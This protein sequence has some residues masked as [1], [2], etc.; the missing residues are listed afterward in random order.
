MLHNAWQ[1]IAQHSAQT[2]LCGIQRGI[3]GSLSYHGCWWCPHFMM[4]APWAFIWGRVLPAL[5]I[6]PA[7]VQLYNSNHFCQAWAMYIHT[8]TKQSKISCCSLKGSQPQRQI[9]GSQELLC[10]PT[11]ALCLMLQLQSTDVHSPPSL[12]GLLL[13][14]ILLLDHFQAKQAPVGHRINQQYQEFSA[15]HKVDMGRR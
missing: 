6:Y 10:C 11:C 14:A 3:T 4:L 8:Y 7:L 15:I 5:K 1:T 2:R 9:N 13:A 12:L